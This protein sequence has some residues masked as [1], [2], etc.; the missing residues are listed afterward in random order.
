ME[1][2]SGAAVL[3]GVA[4]LAWAAACGG[5][6]EEERQGARAE[7]RAAAAGLP[8]TPNTGPM[9]EELAERGEA[10]FQLRGCLACHSVGKG[11]L[12]GPDLAG[13]T[14][15]RSFEWFYHMVTNPDS[16]L[17]NDPTA[18]QLLAEYMT[19]MLD[20]NASP[21]EVRA[22]WEYL[23]HEAEEGGEEGWGG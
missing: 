14:E 21:E 22:I 15:R 12:V 11:R 3:A 13:V 17:R 2:R 9:D 10:A 18:R 7:A 4:A 5:A 8:V 19:P 6:A 16:M 1:M 23:R 20:Q